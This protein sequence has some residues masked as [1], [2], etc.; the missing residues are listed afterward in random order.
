M[1]IICR[2]TT[3]LQ[4]GIRARSYHLDAVSIPRHR[5]RRKAYSGLYISELRELCPRTGGSSHTP[6]P[7]LHH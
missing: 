3:K 5:V 4:I 6:H 2:L 7:R 1:E